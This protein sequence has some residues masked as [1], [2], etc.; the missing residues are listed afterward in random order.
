MNETLVSLN[1]RSADSSTAGQ[2]T[3]KS[4]MEAYMV[5]EQRE[6]WQSSMVFW[7]MAGKWVNKLCC[8]LQAYRS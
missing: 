7:Q 5:T 3:N 4:P 6:A 1:F 8:R 2:N